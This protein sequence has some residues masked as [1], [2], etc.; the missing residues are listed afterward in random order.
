MSDA[1]DDHGHSVA[2]WTVSSLLMLSSIVA[3]AGVVLGNWT[4]FWVGM[5]LTP[6]AGIAGKVLALMG[7]GKQ[8]HTS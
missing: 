4:M 8:T 1:H 5:A 3:T 7:F 6:V 2:A